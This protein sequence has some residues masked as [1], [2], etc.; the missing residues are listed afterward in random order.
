MLTNQNGDLIQKSIKSV[1]NSKKFVYF[2]TEQGKVYKI[3]HQ[4]DAK[5]RVKIL[6]SFETFEQISAG[7]NILLLLSSKGKLFGYKENHDKWVEPPFKLDFFEKDK[8]IELKNI[9]SFL[10]KNT[11]IR[12]IKAAYE[13]SFFV[14]ND[15]S[16]YST[17]S[18]LNYFLGRG[19]DCY[20]PILVSGDIDVKTLGEENIIKIENTCQVVIYLTDKGKVYGN[21]FIVS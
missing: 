16:V 10:P 12:F 20:K 11:G 18:Q 2:L 19:G 9:Q 3:E 7:Y 8:I 5:P 17:D 21:G 4:K 1:V 15:N 14:M 13:S 6:N